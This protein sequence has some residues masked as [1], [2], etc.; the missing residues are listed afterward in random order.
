MRDVAKNTHFSKQ[1]GT[2]LSKTPQLNKIH[3]AF[4]F[5]IGSSSKQIQQTNDRRTAFYL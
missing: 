4:F 3:A 5:L 1:A 2:H